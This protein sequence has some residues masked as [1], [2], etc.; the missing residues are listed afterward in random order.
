M[1]DMPV[2]K[3]FSRS[4]WSSSLSLSLWSDQA[5]SAMVDAEHGYFAK[6]WKALL[7]VFR[8]ERALYN[9]IIPTI[10]DHINVIS[11]SHTL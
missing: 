10:I 9:Y 11:L 5:V 1:P 4:S 8:L 3:H 7:N 6:L 2:S